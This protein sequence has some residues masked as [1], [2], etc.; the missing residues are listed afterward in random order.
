[1]SSMSTWE[2]LGRRWSEVRARA[3]SQLAEA[4]ELA[5]TG[6]ESGLRRAGSL[7]GSAG[8]KMR[9]VHE[10]E[11]VIAAGKAGAA[12]PLGGLKGAAS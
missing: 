9:H 10:W 3:E 6:G 12:T 11:R 1:M 5:A 2:A 8:H 7:R 4:R